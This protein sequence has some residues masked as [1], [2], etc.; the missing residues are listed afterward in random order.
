M[1]KGKQCVNGSQQNI[2]IQRVNLVLDHIYDHLSEELSL[3][4]LADVAGF[5]E[6]HFHRIFKVVTGETVNQM[7]WRAR[8][9]NGANLLRADQ[10]MQVSDAA[11]QC[12]FE[13]LAGF[14]RAFKARFGIPPTSWDRHTRLQ[15]EQRVLEEHFPSYHITEL[16]EYHEQFNV[17]FRHIKAQQLAYIRVYE[18]YLMD[19]RIGRAYQRLIDWFLACGGQLENT[20]L[21]GMSMDDRDIT[22]E[23]LCRFDWCL[24][25]PDGWTGDDEI[26]M[27]HLPACQVA[28]VTMDGGDLQNEDRIWQYLWRYWLPRSNYTPIDLPAMEIYHRFPHELDQHTDGWWDRYYMDCGIPVAKLS[29]G[30]R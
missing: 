20:T 19:D 1:S 4:T 25:V 26:S 24:C 29:N 17:H 27:R 22:P 18:P 12:G 7:V 11:I 30:Q 14:S 3:K 16:Q 10:T 2:Y 9:E 21:Y 13:T 15:S 6:Y 23:K 8:V 28:V 5:S